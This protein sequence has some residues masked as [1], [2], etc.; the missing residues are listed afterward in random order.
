V[1][2]YANSYGSRVFFDDLGPPWP[3]HP[4]T[5]NRSPSQFFESD[6][7]I[8]RFRESNVGNKKPEKF[9]GDRKGWKAFEILRSICFRLEI[10]H[11]STAR[12]FETDLMRDQ[13]P[14]MGSYVWLKYD[15]VRPAFDASFFDVEALEERVLSLKPFHARKFATLNEWVPFLSWFRELQ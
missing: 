7:R 1:Y 5:N 15:R 8:W 3:K 12:K 13:L 11:L 9:V 4:C 6:F 2:F 14:E 10:K